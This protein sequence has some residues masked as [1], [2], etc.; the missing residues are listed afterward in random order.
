VGIQRSTR[1]GAGLS[2]GALIFPGRLVTFPGCVVAACSLRASSSWPVRVVAWEVSTWSARSRV[3]DVIVTETNVDTPVTLHTAPVGTPLPT[4]L[5]DL[6][7]QQ[8][9]TVPRFLADNF[10]TDDQ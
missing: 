1:E 9:S 10:G 2:T 3:S 7:P 4:D 5:T 8:W 6:D